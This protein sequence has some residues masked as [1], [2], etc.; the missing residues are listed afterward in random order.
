MRTKPK[1]EINIGQVERLAAIGCTL[2]EICLNL[3]FSYSTLNRRK[4]EMKELEDAITRGK[5]KGV[6]EIENALFKRAQEGDVHAIKF[7]LCNRTDKWSS[8]YKTEV[9]GANGTPLQ[10]PVINVVFDD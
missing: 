2:E 7:W 6:R 8:I 9:T 10:P 5:A 3:G 1:I 4:K